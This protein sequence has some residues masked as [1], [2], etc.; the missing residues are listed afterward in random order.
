MH[1]EI[2]ELLFFYSQLLAEFHNFVC[3]AVDFSYH[4][5]K[6]FGSPTRDR[7]FP[8]EAIRA[9]RVVLRRGYPGL[10]F[11]KVQS[12][13]EN[14]LPLVAVLRCVFVCI[15]DPMRWGGSSFVASWYKHKRRWVVWRRPP[16]PCAPRLVNVAAEH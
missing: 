1:A 13:E 5:I 3:E 6:H 15:D 12:S 14:S 8:S 9:R 7:V 11:H 4:R 16:A 2:R 10:V